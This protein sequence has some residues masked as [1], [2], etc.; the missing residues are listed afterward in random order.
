MKGLHHINMRKR[1]APGHE[2]YPARTVWLKL[3]DQLVL[4]IG[5]VG[6]LT[7]IPQALKIYLTHDATGVST[8]AWLL[9]GVCDVVWIIYGLAHRDRPIVVAYTLWF[10]VNMLVAVGALIYGAGLF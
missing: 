4:T 9:P 2:P 6:P 3:L 7:S 1:R 8:L 10:F 5:I